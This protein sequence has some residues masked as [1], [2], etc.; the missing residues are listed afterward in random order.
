MKSMTGYGY[1]EY[2][3]EKIDI[4]TELK[5]YNNRYLDL[6]INLPPFFSSLEPVLRNFLSSRIERGKVELYIRVKEIEED[7]TVSIDRGVA[8]AGIDALKQLALI[9][10]INETINLSHLLRME[11]IIK[12]TRNRDADY[13]WKILEPLLEKT[14]LQFDESRTI[15]AVKTGEDIERQIEIISKAVGTA[16]KF[17]SSMEDD[18]K[19]NLKDRFEQLLG[20]MADENRIY[21]ETA[22]MLVRFSINEEIV[23]LKSHIEG[24]KAEISSDSPQIGKKLDFICQEINR[25]INTIGSKSFKVEVNQAVIDARDALE[26]IREQVRNIA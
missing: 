24:F 17:A 16:E 4:V 21:T 5:S 9:A 22:V 10:G 8:L 18:I 20:D 6:Y 15:E 12:K 11:G 14:F 19:K 25:E 26:K 3:D 2:Q 7:S 13:F 23:R 1:S